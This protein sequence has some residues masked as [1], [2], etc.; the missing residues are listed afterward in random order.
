MRPGRT[1]CDFQQLKHTGI[2]ASASVVSGVWHE[3]HLPRT[4]ARQNRGLWSHAAQSRSRLEVTQNVVSQARH[5][6][7]SSP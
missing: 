7:A 4:T 6:F 2:S 5:F 3:I 1:F